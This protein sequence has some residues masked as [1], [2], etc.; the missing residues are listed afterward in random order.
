MRVCIITGGRQAGKLSGQKDIRSKFI[1]LLQDIV[2]TSGR[3]KSPFKK[4]K[5]PNF[6]N[7]IYAR[8]W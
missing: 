6:K 4:T 8:K 7:I 5:H 3:P 2:V 1:D